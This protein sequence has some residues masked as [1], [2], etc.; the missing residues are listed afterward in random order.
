MN[1]LKNLQK[2]KHKQIQVRA[3]FFMG[4]ALFLQGEF[5]LARQAY[6][7]IIQ[8]NAFSGF[9]IKTLERLIACAEHLGM[10][11]KKEQYHSI[12]YDFFRKDRV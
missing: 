5:D 3:Q 9:V 11:E 8:K 4:E 10:K 12:L 6:E 2:S 7:E 1:L